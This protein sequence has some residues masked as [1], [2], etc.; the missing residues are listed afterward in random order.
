[1]LKI[2]VHLT[3][4]VFIAT[5]LVILQTTASNLIWLSSLDMPVSLQ[6]GLTTYFNDLITMNYLNA[7]P[8]P[9][10]Q[11]TV[12]FFALIAVALF[13]A[14]FFARIGLSWIRISKRIAYSLAG[15]AAIIGIVILMPLEFYNLDLLPG[16]R[17]FLGKIS[18]GACGMAS[19]F[20]FGSSLK[21]RK[22]Q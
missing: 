11:T 5:A 17:T 18:L 4:A 20:Y 21:E 1:M 12:P 9:R 19:G 14:F 10:L 8:V 22:S 6:V 16:A 3:I 13:I 2:S 7:L 15:G